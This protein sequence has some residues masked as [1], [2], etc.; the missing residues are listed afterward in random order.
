MNGEVARRLGV[1]GPPVHAPTVV[2]HMFSVPK[3]FV[4]YLIGFAVSPWS[5]FTPF[6][7]GAQLA[8]K[9][10]S[11]GEIGWYPKARKVR[12]GIEG[13]VSAEPGGVKLKHEKKK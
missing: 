3:I 13:A 1:W 8:S 12:P 10:I 2:Q 6:K 5:P 11:A 4:T 9:R 7:G